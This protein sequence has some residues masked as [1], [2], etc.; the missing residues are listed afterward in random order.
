MQS[1][2]AHWARKLKMLC[3][4]ENL[5][6][7]TATTGQAISSALVIVFNLFSFYL[8]FLL[9]YDYWRLISF[10][11]YWWQLYLH[12]NRSKAKKK[13]GYKKGVN[14]EELSPHTSLTLS[15]KIYSICKLWYKIPNL[16]FKG[17]NKLTRR[18][19][20]GLF[21]HLETERKSVWDK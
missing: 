5:W 19:L 13:D 6:Y 2:S 17:Y 7:L 12:K 3:T 4:K 15:L 10:F 21:L 1:N 20:S 14:R 11:L 9:C 8:Y 16:L 18:L